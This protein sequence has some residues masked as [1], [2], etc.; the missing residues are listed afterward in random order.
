MASILRSKDD[1]SA[2]LFI[3]NFRLRCKTKGQKNGFVIWIIA[4]RFPLLES[5][6]INKYF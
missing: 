6:R 3:F 5:R 4:S 1:G 2:C